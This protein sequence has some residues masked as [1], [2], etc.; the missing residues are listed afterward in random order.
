MQ[1]TKMA[2]LA[3]SC[4]PPSVQ[5]GRRAPTHS[6]FEPSFPRVRVS[7]RVS[8][9]CGWIHPGLNGQPIAASG[10]RDQMRD[11][12][13]LS[14]R[15]GRGLLRLVS[16]CRRQCS[17]VESSLRSKALARANMSETVSFS[18]LG[19]LRYSRVVWRR[20]PRSLDWL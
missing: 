1:L 16:Q 18:W 14:E 5:Q 11:G 3:L 7:D 6:S 12:R 20:M 13:P 2:V 17:Q 9:R 15:L 8:P 19:S 10:S 4:R